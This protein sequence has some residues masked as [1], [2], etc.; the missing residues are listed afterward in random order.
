[1]SRTCSS[2]EQW[3]CCFNSILSWH[4]GK[5][6][7]VVCSVPTLLQGNQRVWSA[8]CVVQLQRRCTCWS[9][10]LPPLGKLLMGKNVTRY[11]MVK[12]I[13]GNVQFCIGSGSSSEGKDAGERLCI[14]WKLMYVLS[15]IFHMFTGGYCNLFIYCNFIN[16]YYTLCQFCPSARLKIRFDR[17]PLWE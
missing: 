6:L 14:W 7:Q 15:E 12:L 17:D 3:C 5:N 16:S 2:V 11:I 8:K 4:Q 13:S 9:W 1:M 10:K